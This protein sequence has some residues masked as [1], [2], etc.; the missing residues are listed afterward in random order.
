LVPTFGTLSSSALGAAGGAAVSILGASAWVQPGSA[1]PQ[2]AA[3]RHSVKNARKFD[4]MGGIDLRWRRIGILRW[5]RGSSKSR[6]LPAG[7][8][9]RESVSDQ[10]IEDA[11]I[12]KW[13]RRSFT[14]RL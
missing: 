3:T 8:V 4:F 6:C 9:Q 2:G 10:T 14:L 1:P 11:R 13:V 12:W 7:A 5:R